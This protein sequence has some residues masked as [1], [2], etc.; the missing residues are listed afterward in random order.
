MKVIHRGQKKVII[1]VEKKKMLWCRNHKPSE[2]EE[3]GH[4]EW[5]TQY[6][7]YSLG[8]VATYRKSAVRVTSSTFTVSRYVTAISWETTWVTYRKT[9]TFTV[10]HNCPLVWRRVGFYVKQKW[11]QNFAFSSNFPTTK[12][13]NS[14]TLPTTI[15]LLLMVENPGSDDYHDHINML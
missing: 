12:S 10:F 1:P 7:H 15:G 6:Q 14:R 4:R 3:W 2:T 9:E 13:K 5:L 8:Q 11:M